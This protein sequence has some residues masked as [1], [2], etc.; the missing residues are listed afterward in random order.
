[1]VRKALQWSEVECVSGVQSLAIRWQAPPRE[2]ASQMIFRLFE[3]IND[4]ASGAGEIFFPSVA[5]KRI[6]ASKETSEAPWKVG[7]YPEVW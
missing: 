1:M 4:F 2:V 7:V 6:L 3:R 5:K